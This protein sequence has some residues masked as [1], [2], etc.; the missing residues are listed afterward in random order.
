L[1]SAVDLTPDDDH[2]NC[3]AN[4]IPRDDID[5]AGVNQSCYLVRGG[6]SDGH[7]D[8]KTDVAAATAREGDFFYQLR[9]DDLIN[10]NA[11]EPAMEGANSGDL[12]AHKPDAW[13]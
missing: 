11:E 6:R 2:R 8:G 13:F 10:A 1:Q 3:M 5:A 12:A 7:G 4:H 9:Y